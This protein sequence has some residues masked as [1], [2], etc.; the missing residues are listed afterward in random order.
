MSQTAEE[1]ARVLKNPAPI[2]TCEGFVDNYL[3][4][5]L[6][7]YIGLIEHRLQTITDLNEAII[8]KFNEAGIV[9]PVP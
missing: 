9:I 7:C 4:I 3:R 8:R 1:H 6:G 5:N 2:V